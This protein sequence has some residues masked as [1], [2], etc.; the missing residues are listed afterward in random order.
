ME[1][2]E[3]FFMMG[4]KKWDVLYLTFEQVKE[5]LAEAGTTVLV[6]AREPASMEQIQN[7]VVADG[8]AT[9]FVVA[10]KVEF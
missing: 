7:P 9:V 8:K 4:K 10:Q 1:E 2:R 5:A 6:A 3:S